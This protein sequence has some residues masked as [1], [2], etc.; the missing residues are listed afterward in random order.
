MLGRTMR[1]LAYVAKLNEPACRVIPFTAHGPSGKPHRIPSP[2]PRQ[3][4]A[5]HRVAKVAEI[6]Q[7]LLRWSLTLM[8]W[9]GALPAPPASQRKP[10]SME[11]GAIL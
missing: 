5:T 4:S 2:L 11:P 7:F 1:A 10:L 9:R 8:P 3:P 6:S